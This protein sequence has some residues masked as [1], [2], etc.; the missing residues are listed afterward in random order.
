[1]T[2]VFAIKVDDEIDNELGWVGAGP[3][4]V[5]KRVRAC[6]ERKQDAEE[7]RDLF[8]RKVPGFHFEVEPVALED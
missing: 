4:F 1:M 5:T 6:Y 8:A 2:T 3:N 7:V